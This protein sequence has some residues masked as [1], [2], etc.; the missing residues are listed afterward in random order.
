MGI[1]IALIPFFF[2]KGSEISGGDFT[3]SDVQVVGMSATL[4]NLGMLATWLNAD[5]FATEYRPVPLVEKMKVGRT[6]LDRKLQKISEIN[7]EDMING[8][9]EHVIPLCLETIR[10]CCSVLIFCPTKQ[11]CETLAATI[12]RNLKR[13]LIA[14]DTKDTETTNPLMKDT[15]TRC[16]DAVAIKEVLEQL[17][18]SPVGLDKA[19]AEV[20]SSGVSFHH[21]GL[22]FDERDVIEGAF[23]GGAIRVLVATS[24]LSSGRSQFD[25]NFRYSSTVG[26]KALAR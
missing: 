7:S 10:D 23:R 15:R 1:F 20:V 6:I 12:A 4:P 9:E 11:W 5:V 8:D 16:L 24:T 17:K 2:V 22:T 25:F 13:L 3:P 18:R 14:D 21:A 19:L 26:G